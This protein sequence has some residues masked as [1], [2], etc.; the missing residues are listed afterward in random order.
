MTKP[1]L[2][3]D[4]ILPNMLFYTLIAV[5]ILTILIYF[6]CKLY[7]RP[8]PGIPYNTPSSKR[9]MGDLPELLQYFRVH[10]ETG[11]FLFS[12]CTSLKSPIIQL[13]IRPMSA[14]FIIL[15]D[16]RETED[17]MLRRTKE[18]DRAP[19][20]SDIFK[21]LIPHASIVKQTTPEFK[22]QRR[23]WMDVMKPT[24]LRRVVA[25]NIHKSSMEL[26]EL[27]KEKALLAEGR[28]FAVQSDFETAAFDAIW[29]A[30]LG[31]E[32]GGTRADIKALKTVQAINLPDSEEEAAILPS[33]PRSELY[34]AIA[35]LNHSVEK[36]MASPSPTWHHWFIRQTAQYKNY[37]A[38]KDHEIR[39]IMRGAHRR[40]RDILEKDNVGEEHD[41]CAVDLVLRREM[42][43]AQSA[44]LPLLKEENLEIQ[45]EL[46]MLLVAVSLP[47][48]P[49]Q[50]SQL[51]E[52]ITRATKQRPQH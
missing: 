52:L 6:T 16:A 5:T 42:V 22:R 24:F 26:V 39:K 3:I 14:P 21:P 41:T 4:T 17:I 38:I 50:I 1:T 8:Y 12:Q 45:D 37:N 30:I 2:F 44:G 47:S 35:Y 28:P 23:L 27:W 10:K 36:I 15:T 9:M 31:S 43:A 40:F 34:Q 20:T 49:F 7:P 13:F 25:P 29:V 19:S 48:N 32:L 18:F 33:T 51:I 46:L 11:P